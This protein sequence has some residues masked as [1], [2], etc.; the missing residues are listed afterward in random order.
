MHKNLKIG[1]IYIDFTYKY[2]DFFAD[3]I[4]AF[5]THVLNKD[6]KSMYVHVEDKIE[7]PQRPVTLFFKNR[8]KMETH[9]DCYI[10]T[11][12]D[13]EVKHLIYYTYDYKEIVITLSSKIKD[14]LAEFEYVLSG[15]L[16]F[17]IALSENYLPVHATCI[18][19]KDFTF[20]LLGSSEEKTHQTISFLSAFPDAVLIN[21]D[22]PLL[23]YQ[24]NQAHVC[25]SPWSGERAIKKDIIKPLDYIFFINPASESEILSLDK[26]VKASELSRNVHRANQEFLFEKTTKLVNTVTSNI[27]IFQFNSTYSISSSIE[28]VRF[29]KEGNN[30]DNLISIKP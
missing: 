13:N 4:E 26:S 23:F 2:D 29:M 24:N 27:P 12:E 28:L 18:S 6:F 17:D 10:V 20:L 25:G 5:E 19:Y 21:E 3:K 16:F 14:R 7:I 11:I 1:N 9:K 30:L 15:I 22:K 8:Y